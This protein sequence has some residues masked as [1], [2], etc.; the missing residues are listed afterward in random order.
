MSVLIKRD[1]VTALRVTAAR[2]RIGASYQ[3]GHFGA[4]N[5]GHLAH[6]L[7][8]R[9]AA[10][11]HDAAI[12]RASSFKTP[13][14][15]WS[16]AAVDYCPLSGLPLDDIIDEM[17]A[18]GLTLHEIKHLE[19]LSDRRILR[20]LPLEKRDLRRNRREDVVVYFETW[21]ELLEEQLA[22]TSAEELPFPLAAE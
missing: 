21:A 6:T 20:R 22:Q 12:E 16:E 11:I 5:C 8:K 1:L 17:L 4:C 13:V 14:D 18:A 3:W 7:T 9:S 10:E 2:L 19:T 15:D